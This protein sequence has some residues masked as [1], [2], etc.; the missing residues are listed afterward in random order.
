M[1]AE[2]VPTK[3]PQGRD[4]GL[5]V[6]LSFGFTTKGESFV[7]REA[8]WEYTKGLG[9][10][11]QPGPWITA[12][13]QAEARRGGFSRNCGLG[14]RGGPLTPADFP[15]SQYKTHTHP[16]RQHSFWPLIPRVNK[17]E[18]GG[19]AWMMAPGLV[20]C[21]VDTRSARACFSRLNVAHQGGVGV[22][23][24]PEDRLGFHQRLPCDGGGL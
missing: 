1:R 15:P 11:G 6:G 17:L 20:A 23:L 19:G 14:L 3:A 18:G 22:F 21:A 8:A 16:L 12:L 9:P 10:G 24:D 4:S 5:K 2:L 7:S 13:G